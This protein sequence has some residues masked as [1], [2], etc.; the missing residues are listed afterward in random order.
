MLIPPNVR[1]YKSESVQFDFIELSLTQSWWI[2]CVKNVQIVL[3][4]ARQ[5]NPIQVVV[6]A[7]T[8]RFKD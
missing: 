5:K 2:V 7:A 8:L 4:N 3:R 1:I 6:R